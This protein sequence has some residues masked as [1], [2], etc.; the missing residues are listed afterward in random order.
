MLILLE[1]SLYIN[2]QPPHFSDYYS[3]TTLTQPYFTS[4]LLYLLIICI[5]LILI[6]SH[7]ILFFSSRHYSFF[8]LESYLNNSHISL[9][10]QK[11]Y[12]FLIKY[13]YCPYSLIFHSFVFL[14]IFNVII[15]FAIVIF[16]SSIISS[17]FLISNLFIQI[18]IIFF[19]IIFRCYYFFQ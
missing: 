7:L 17:S 18:F 10:V 1:Y 8:V 2:S 4:Y 6:V 11:M 19:I 13:L 16:L 3:F 12:F 15:F 9:Q 14:S 5:Y